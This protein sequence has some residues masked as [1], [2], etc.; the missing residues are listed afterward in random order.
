MTSAYDAI[1]GIRP[2]VRRDVLF[3]KMPDG[4]LFHNSREGFQIRS[5]KGYEFAS[6]I[7]PHLNGEK[8]V[9]EICAG[10]REPQRAMVTDLVNALLS[11]GFARDAHPAGPGAA[12]LD[13]EVRA[14]FAEQ[15][16]Y[17]D[18]HV[19]NAE[20]RFAR[21]RATR[22]A[23]VGDDMVARWCALSLIRNGA[24]QVAVTDRF[25]EVTEEAG[26]LT[27]RGCPAA[28]HLLPATAGS[29]GRRE[30]EEYDV[31]VVGPGSGGPRRILTWLSGARPDGQV[32]L[33]ASLAGRRAVIGP[34]TADGTRGCWACAA[35][36]LGA[37]DTSGASGDLWSRAALPG[38]DQP[39]LVPSRPLAAMLGNLLGY[40]VFRL[41]TGAL[42]AET[43][44]RIVVQELD[45]MDVTTERVLPHPRCPFCAGGS[46]DAA[47]ERVEPAEPAPHRAPRTDATAE[48]EERLLRALRDRSVLVGAVAGVFTGFDDD[49]LTQSPLKATLLRFGLGAQPPRTLAAFDPHTVLDAR[50]RAL[51]EAAVIY[52]DRVVP[53][54][55]VVRDGG[56]PRVSPHRL[57]TAG[58]T[59]GPDAPVSGWVVTASLL[60]GE[61]AMVPA[62]A[63]G[64]YSRYNDDRVWLPGAPG[65]GA[66]A[67][68]D[69]AVYRGLLAVI[70]HEAVD[71]ALRG[72]RAV[73]RIAPESVGDVPELVFLTRCAEHLGV[74]LELLDLGEPG[75]TSAHAVL[76][77]AGASYAVACAP[78]AE[79]AAVR[80]ACDLLGR[81][82][83]GRDPAAA[84]VADTEPF[85][86]LDASAL[87][88]TGESPLG[89]AAPTT[90]RAI[91]DR[92]RERGSDLFAVDRTS[93]DLRRAGVTTARVL[94]TTAG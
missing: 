58:G 29:P 73:T 41:R 12:P 63:V 16:G 8:Q 44:G 6:L 69:E 91:L 90:W 2:K 10:L 55:A 4:V 51:R 52:T 40:E 11:H 80:A 3:A 30:L 19:D 57:V 82:Q 47:V 14:V 7:L 17:V 43:D 24:A 93:E 27:A 37:N 21:F 81:I 28:V 85:D 92:L 60:T 68:V 84:E 88:V 13:A 26:R 38:T 59:H 75:H 78:R 79:S 23:V 66:G 22:V 62:G 76:A 18:H 87:A 86:A 50:L 39:P 15:I 36:R 94:L 48:D 61:R 33:P 54:R 31:V 20:E 9:S 25:A 53:L 5:E 64:T 34:L 42:P 77:R 71:Q 45:S 32:L 56:L 72:R 65:T 67:T 70:A 49:A 1:S 89:A 83:L 35:L 46:A 74:A